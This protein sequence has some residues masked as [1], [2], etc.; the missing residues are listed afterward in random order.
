M[1]MRVADQSS[2]LATQGQDR[3][4]LTTMGFL[5]DC[6]KY[7]RQREFRP[8]GECSVIGATHR[9]ASHVAILGSFFA[10]AQRQKI[11]TDL[12]FKGD[13]S[14]FVRW[15]HD[16][17]PMMLAFGA[18]QPLLEES[19]RYLIREKDSR[20]ISRWK[21]VP[22]EE[23]QKVH[24]GAATHAG[25][26]EVFGQLL[27]VIVTRPPRPE[28]VEE[29]L[30][31]GIFI[32]PSILES[33]CADCLL[34]AAAAG[35][36]F[37]SLDGIREICSKV[38]WFCLS[39]FP[40]GV[41]SNLRMQGYMAFSLHDIPNLLLFDGPCVQHI[42]H[43]ICVKGMQEDKLLGHVHAV[44]MVLSNKSHQPTC[45]AALKRFFMDNLD[46]LIGEPDPVQIRMQKQ[47][48]SFTLLRACDH[49][50]GSIMPGD[51]AS[52]SKLRTAV[53]EF[54]FWNNWD[55]RSQDVKKLK[56][57]WTSEMSRKYP[58]GLSNSE[59][60]DILVATWTQLSLL[61]STS[62]AVCKSRWWTMTSA[63]AQQVLPNN[64]NDA[65]SAVMQLSFPTWDSGL[66]P[67][68]TD[69]AGGLLFPS[70]FFYMSSRF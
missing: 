8:E 7:V 70:E 58:E 23:Y 53:A 1:V 9:Q 24:P 5:H 48:L 3:K 15:H 12:D 50:A 62:K 25:V 19:A 33:T 55:W 49:T 69:D 20:G 22:F 38:D 45:Q 4:Q 61:T 35:S 54:A 32:P 29:E 2:L 30:K 41:S 18:L 66:P 21:A 17:T 60:C 43:R 16:A 67:Q 51:S 59:I 47:L 11:T 68:G 34:D 27:D 37:V 63:L 64:V 40:D 31:H 13:E 44:H 57:R 39:T 10:R 52:D 42:F 46:P 14:V 56:M 6:W 26:L 65:L 28:S 36:D